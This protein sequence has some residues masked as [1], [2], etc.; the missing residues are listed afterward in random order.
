MESRA[1]NQDG[2]GTIDAVERLRSRSLPFKRSHV[3][4]LSIDR[5]VVVEE[6]CENLPSRLRIRD[7]TFVRQNVSAGAFAAFHKHA[8]KLVQ[9]VERF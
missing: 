2:V 5:F 4:S 9:V 3:E 8:G 7:A 1:A 6:K